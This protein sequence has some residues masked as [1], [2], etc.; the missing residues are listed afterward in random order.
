MRV[1]LT[2][3][4]GFIGSAV[5][6]ELLGAGHRVTGLARSDEAARALAAA[7]AE[8]HRGS[9]DDPDS[10]HAGA[11]KSDGVIHLAF[12]H[13]FSNFAASL[14]AEFRAVETIGEALVGSDRPFAIASGMLGLAPGRQLVE[15]DVAPPEWPRARSEE[16]LQ[17]LATRGVRT[18]SIRL[19][20]TV[21][22]EGD[23]GF[24]PGLIQLARGKGAAAYIGDGANR[25]PA[26]HRRD[27][28]RLFR[29]AIEKGA[30]GS[31]FHAAAE[32][33]IPTRTIATAM[34]E[35]L[36]LPVVAR[37]FDEAEAYYGFLGRFF[38]LDAPASSAV[39]RS[40][41]GWEPREPGLLEDMKAHYFAPPTKG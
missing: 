22:G 16:I 13:D 6:P 38:A 9:L 34:G 30:A 24:V 23:H 37:S 29:L 12:I 36:G 7:G 8:V 14:T 32:E 21:H 4:S 10:L 28:A 40:Q 26:V 27:A 33:G 17:E 35:G 18:S 5:I 3:A 39:T 25:W 1:F 19:P 20:P 41:L 2:G 31:R 15:S 11:A